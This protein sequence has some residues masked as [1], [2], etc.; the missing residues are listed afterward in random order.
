VWLL[1]KKHENAIHYASKAYL[2]NGETVSHFLKNAIQCNTI[3][4]IG[5]NVATKCNTVY[6]VRKD[7]FI[8]HCQLIIYKEK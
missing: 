3:Q 1:A 2:S 4:Y 7:F 5:F 8:K 6:Y